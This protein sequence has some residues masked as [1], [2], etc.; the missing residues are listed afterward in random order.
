MGDAEHVPGEGVAHDGVLHEVGGFAVRIGTGVDEHPVFRERGHDAGDGGALNVGDGAQFDERGG[1][2][3]AG[4]TSADDGVST[5]IF[6]QIDGAGDGAVFFLPHGIEAAVAHIDDLRCGDDF[7]LGAH[8]E[9]LGGHFALHDLRDADEENL[10]DL[11]QG[12]EGELDAA[13][14]VLRGVIAAHDIESDFHSGRKEGRVE[15]SEGTGQFSAS[16][17]DLKR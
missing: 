8:F 10:L 17:A 1:D 15:V 12:L 13:N 9:A 5:S 11:R 7:E 3:G 4:V 6:D 14:R 16:R 2:G